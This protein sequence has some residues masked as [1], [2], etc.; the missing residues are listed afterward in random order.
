MATSATAIRVAVAAGV[1]RVGQPIAQLNKYPIIPVVVIIFF[2]LMAILALVVTPYSP[3]K[4]SL[5]EKNIPP[6]L[7]KR[8]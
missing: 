2:F 6:R 5:P 4:I 3:T 7:A 1:S 8:G